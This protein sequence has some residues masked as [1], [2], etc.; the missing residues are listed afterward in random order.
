MNSAT[1]HELSIWT[2]IR[3]RFN[4]YIHICQNTDC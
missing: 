4:D 1:T 2:D 3:R